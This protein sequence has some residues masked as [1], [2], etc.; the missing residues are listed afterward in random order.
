[1]AT[2]AERSA[3]MREKWIEVGR[4]LFSRDGFDAT[5]TNALLEGA[6]ASKG[7]LY[8]HFSSKRALFEAVFE[9]VSQDAIA[10]ALAKP[11]P[12][13]S[14][15]SAKDQLV[16]GALA[17]LDE[18]RRPEIARVL[19]DEGPRVLGFERA[20]DLEARTSLALMT[21]SLETAVAAGEILV[22][23]IELMAR[24]LNAV[25][26]EAALIELRS[27]ESGARDRVEASLR[28]LIDGLA[29][30]GR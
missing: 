30:G 25:L 27:A 11:T 5:S 12:A 24:L 29:P 9:A 6:G 17:W 21:R 18:V 28:A 16:A 1:M 13:R 19:L 3:Q 26:A 4:A 15:Q 20:R 8:H 14:A 7:A 22:P 2:Q 10:G 23:D